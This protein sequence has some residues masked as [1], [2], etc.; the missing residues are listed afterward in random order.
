M[1]VIVWK[2]FGLA[3]SMGTFADVTVRW[4]LS[5][6]LF[7]LYPGARSWVNIDDIASHHVQILKMF[8]RFGEGLS[9]IV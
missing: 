5:Y 7:L 1:D 2:D 6:L 9:V 8:G 4:G 3:F